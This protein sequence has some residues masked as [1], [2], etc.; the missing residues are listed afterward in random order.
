MAHASAATAAHLDFRIKFIQVSAVL[1]PPDA[2]HPDQLTRMLQPPDV[3]TMQ[4]LLLGDD[5]PSARNLICCALEREG[6]AV[7]MTLVDR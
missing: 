2:I 1:W 3:S 6:I 7:T 5:R 4:V